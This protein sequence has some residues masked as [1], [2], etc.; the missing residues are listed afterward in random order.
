MPIS[1]QRQI[2]NPKKIQSISSSALDSVDVFRTSHKD[3]VVLGA[4]ED[5][6]NGKEQVNDVKVE[7]DRSS[8]LLLN[9]H[10]S[11]NHL[12][13]NLLKSRSQYYFFENSLE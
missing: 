4:V 2:M 7:A 6:E 5:S 11:H 10:V 1:N 9:M 3:L 12:S 13:I 8:D